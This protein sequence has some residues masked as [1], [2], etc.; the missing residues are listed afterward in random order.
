[1][2]RPRACTAHTRK[3][4]ARQSA[5]VRACVRGT[6]AAEEGVGVESPVHLREELAHAVQA[7]RNR[8]GAR[9]R[10]VPRVR[11]PAKQ[12]TQC[13]LSDTEGK[14]PPPL[15]EM[16]RRTCPPHR[17]TGAS[18]PWRA[19]TLQRCRRLSRAAAATSRDGAALA[20]RTGTGERCGARWG[21]TVPRQAGCAARAAGL[22]RPMRCG[23][24][25]RPALAAAQCVQPASRG[26]LQ[27]V[28][29]RHG[30]ICVVGQGAASPRA[31]GTIRLA[32]RP[33]LRW[34]RRCREP[35]Q[36]HTPA[37]GHAPA[38]ARAGA[39]RASGKAA[40]PEPTVTV[41]V[42]VP[43]PVHVHVPVPV[44]V[45]VHVPVTVPAVPVPGRCRARS[46]IPS[47]NSRG[48]SWAGRCS[49]HRRY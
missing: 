46:A 39:T 27:P 8:L 21:A 26:R 45:T 11:Q 40:R 17:H 31:S 37:H 30:P 15:S 29:A 23:C 44:I 47:R 43:V 1:M 49:R 48:P 42:T 32:H 38:Q 20:R 14:S 28:G 5:C 9:R 13:G 25:R 4:R 3:D 36:A 6:A 7:R 41:P 24:R 35:D 18:L 16:L 19:R 2:W 12:M 34:R 10:A 33:S 22:A